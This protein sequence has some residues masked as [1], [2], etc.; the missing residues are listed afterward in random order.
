MSGETVHIAVPHGHR[1]LIVGR[2]DSLEALRVSCE[3]GSRDAMHTSGLGKAYLA[4]LS[5]DQLDA[6]IDRLDLEEL[7]P[8]SIAAEADLRDDVIRTREWG[9]SLDFEEGRLGVCC[10]G[11]SFRLGSHLDEVA[12]SNAG[13]SYRWPKDKMM[14]L[15]L[16]KRVS[17][18]RPHLP[19]HPR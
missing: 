4:L 12:L 5:D 16:L 9:Y 19:I 18:I 6:V 8:F 3:P 7:T 14:A 10:M 11:F 17:A 1:M 13:S 2:V 15:A